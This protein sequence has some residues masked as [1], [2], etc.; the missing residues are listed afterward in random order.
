MEVLYGGTQAPI[1]I[2][3]GFWVSIGPVINLFFITA[4]SGSQIFKKIKNQD[5]SHIFLKI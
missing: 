1:I 4:C 2:T 5:H 3:Y